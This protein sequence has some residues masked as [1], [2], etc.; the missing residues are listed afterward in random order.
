[1]FLGPFFSSGSASWLEMGR[2]LRHFDLEALTSSVSFLIICT[3]TEHRRPSHEPGPP[4]DKGFLEKAVPCDM[5]LETDP[6]D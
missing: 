6:T 1:M 2:H 4:G 3:A 5:Q